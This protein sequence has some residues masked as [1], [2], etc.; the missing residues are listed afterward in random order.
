LVGVPYAWA[1]SALNIGLLGKLDDVSVLP[2]LIGS[3]LGLEDETW[4]PLFADDARGA[5]SLSTTLATEITQRLK[6]AGLKVSEKSRNQIWVSIYGGGRVVGSCALNTFL[7]EV[8]VG[9]G[10]S[11]ARARA[12]MS[13]ATNAEL[14]E[15]LRAAAL[16]VIDE[17]VAQRA[18]YRES[19]K[20]KR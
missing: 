11:S 4:R 2:V 7:V 19:L 1:T 13:E 9:A 15:K 8:W 3:P 12:V 14:A 17:L 20:E 5:E 18:R 16:E 6:A 10:E